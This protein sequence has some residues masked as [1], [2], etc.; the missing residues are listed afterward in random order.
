[1]A[2]DRN[3]QD[4][5]AVSQHVLTTTDQIRKLE[6][7]KRAVEPGS[8]RFMELS[9]QIERLAADVRIV[10]AAETDIATE[11]AGE[12]KLPTIEEAD[13]KAPTGA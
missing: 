11:V 3:I 4:L 12:A 9:D 7:E 6:L 13:A 2:V 10:S 1:M 5:Q 8:A